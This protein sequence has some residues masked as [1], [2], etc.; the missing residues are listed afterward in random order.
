MDH[1]RT[2][3]QQSKDAT[4]KAVRP[5]SVASQ[6]EEED[7]MDEDVEEERAS[8][9][10]TEEEQD[11]NSSIDSIEEHE[12]EHDEHEEE[13]PMEDEIEEEPLIEPDPTP[14]ATGSSNNTSA[15]F[16]S[17][18][19]S[20]R[21]LQSF[22]ASQ[23]HAAPRSDQVWQGH[24]L[25]FWVRR[26][27][28]KYKKGKLSPKQIQQLEELPGFVW[29]ATNNIGKP[30][31]QKEAGTT[32]TTTTTTR[33]IASTSPWEEL[34]RVLQNYVQE[35]GHAAPPR[36][37]LYQGHRLGHWV[38]RQREQRVK[39]TPS[40]R[41]RLQ[42][43]PGFVWKAADAASALT[44]NEG[45]HHPSEDDDTPAPAVEEEEDQED[46]ENANHEEL[47]ETSQ[48]QSTTSTPPQ[49]VS[50][51]APAPTAAWERAYRLLQAYQKQHGHAA[52]TYSLVFRGHNLGFWVRRQRYNRKQAK[53]SPDQIARLSALPGFIWNATAGGGRGRAVPASKEEEPTT[54]ST[55][56]EEEDKAEEDSSSNDDEEETGGTKRS[57][58]DNPLAPASNGGE[59]VTACPHCQ[60]PI[61]IPPAKR[62]RMEEPEQANDDNTTRTAPQPRGARASCSFRD[63]APPEHARLELQT[64][65][66]TTAIGLSPIPQEMNDYALELLDLGFHSVP[67]IQQWCTASDVD[68]WTW[69]KTIHKRLF[70]AQAGLLLD[71]QNDQD[72]PDPTLPEEDER[73]NTPTT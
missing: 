18:E 72:D 59:I 46:A 47:P 25:G 50:S 49:E 37:E 38:T 51:S 42:A 71:D 10:S 39:L 65:L 19:D 29:T 20:W 64:W 26:Q 67:V 44:S 8:G 61:G 41:Q 69:M 57:A 27:R 43:L 22:Q 52:P 6:Q 17:W 68:S 40:Q 2:Q 66:S 4:K 3:P 7:R 53:L 1:R 34:F 13:E 11:D 60:K 54:I 32:T 15:R 16:P 55:K 36:K 70:L 48:Q 33:I 14:L 56:R 5:E 21:N 45:R 12:H 35:Y 30:K 23:G 73:N 62:P 63:S 9:T 31:K 24:N 28:L 58:N